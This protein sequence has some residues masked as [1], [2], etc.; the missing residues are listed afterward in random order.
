MCFV[1]AHLSG[2]GAC[3][4]ALGLICGKIK[5][6]W[7][8]TERRFLNIPRFDRRRVSVKRLDLAVPGYSTMVCGLIGVGHAFLSEQGIFFNGYPVRSNASRLGLEDSNRFYR[9]YGKRDRNF[10]M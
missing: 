4:D 7:R 8:A 2:R 1:I 10:A 6:A 9:S 5:L 3:I